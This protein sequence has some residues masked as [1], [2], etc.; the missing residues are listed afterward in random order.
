MK[1]PKLTKEV[2]EKI[3]KEHQ[4]LLQKEGLAEDIAD[5]DLENDEVQY[6]NHIREELANYFDCDIEDVEQLD[7]HRFSVGVHE[8]WVGTEEEAREAAVDYAYQALEEM[9]LE[10]L[11]DSYREYVLNDDRF[12]DY[13]TVRGWMEESNRAYAEDIENES[14]MEFGNRLISEMYDCEVLTDADFEEDEDGYV[15][16]LTL[17]PEVESK[18]YNKIDE[19]VAYLGEQEDPVEWLQS[20]YSSSDLL[21]VVEDNNLLDVQA[22]AEDCVDTD[23]V[24]HFLASYDGNEIELRDDLFAYKQN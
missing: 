15:D 19:F 4:R 16:H 3:D 14:D 9:G 11:S 7:D 12:F 23:G 13:D 5:P 10:A 20:M 21:R 8:Y 2:A 6:G 22:V 1:L 17:K 24:A 18:F